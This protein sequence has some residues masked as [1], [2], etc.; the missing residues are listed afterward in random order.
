[1]RLLTQYARLNLRYCSWPDVGW[2]FHWAGRWWGSRVAQRHPSRGFPLSSHPRWRDHQL[3]SQTG[4]LILYSRNI[5]ENF[6]FEEI[7]SMLI[8]PHP[9]HSI[10]DIPVPYKSCQHF[11]RVPVPVPYWKTQK[12][13]T[14]FNT[15]PIRRQYLHVPTYRLTKTTYLILNLFHLYLYQLFSQF[16]LLLTSGSRG[17]SCCPEQKAGIE[18]WT[19]RNI[20]RRWCTW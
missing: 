5:T 6:M 18:P 15:G 1:M 17:L 16:F 13:A 11:Y 10:Y 20:C 12:L 2:V 4:I 3:L 7:F 8:R 19:L 14:P 9:T